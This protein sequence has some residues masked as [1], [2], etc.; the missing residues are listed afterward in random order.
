LNYQF[1]D[2]PVPEGYTPQSYLEELCYQ[3]AQRRYGGINARVRERLQQEFDLIRQHRLAGFLL[4]YHQ[5]IQLARE[6]MIELGLSDREIPLEE[7][8]PGRGRGSSV[9]M[10]VGY[11]IGLSHIDPLQ[12]NLSLERF[13]PENLAS[14]PDIDLDFP[15]TIREE[16]IKRVH[17]EWGWDRAALTG[18]ISTY[19]MKG[20]IRDL[21]K[22]LGLPRQDV[23]ALAKRVESHSARD[24]PLEME[25]LP[26]FRERIDAPVWRD[27]VDL[28]AQLDGFPKYLAQ[29]P[30]GMIFSSS[31][32]T[33]LAP[34][35]PSAIEG[36]YICQW[37]KDAIGSAGFIK[38]DFLALGALSQM[39]EALQLIEEREGRYIDLSRIDHEDG[40]VYQ[41]L[42]QGI[43]SA[44]FRWRAR[45]SARPSPG[46]SPRTWWRWP[47][48]WPP[49][50]RALGPTTGSACSSSGGTIR[51]LPGTTTIPWSGG[52]LSA[53]WESSCSRTRSISWLSTWPASP[54]RKR[55][56]S[57]GLSGGKPWSTWCWPE[58]SMPWCGTGNQPF[59][60]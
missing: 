21:G 32:L 14:V 17:Q 10:L 55:T 51:K 27:L 41:M 29:H 12:Y 22:A 44:S 52:P 31:P 42:H 33:D 54:Q 24:L 46:S 3:A 48:K 49:S 30:G 35:Q 11:L 56:S 20:A 8:P 37:D 16:L 36:R 38:I 40:A 23:D 18:M 26:E 7:R 50:G 6:I 2:Y 43:P 9:A 60:K 53:P 4:W 1:P 25:S 47:W 57:G 13:L 5:I 28:A 39:Q 45:P 59:G 34:V 15:R 19:E 58:L